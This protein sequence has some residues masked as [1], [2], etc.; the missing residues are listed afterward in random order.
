MSELRLDPTTKEWVIFATE[1]SRRPHE[2]QR[3]GISPTPLPAVNR[4]PFCPGN[5]DLTPATIYQLPFTNPWS[6]RVVPNRFPALRIED[7]TER[8]TNGDLFVTMGGVGAHEVI[9]ES[10]HHDR[11]LPYLSDDEMVAVVRVFLART[12][13]LMRDP[14]FKL[15]LIFKNHG[16]T[17]GTSLEHPHCQLVATPVVPRLVRLKYDVAE[18]HFDITGKCLYCQI[19][20]DEL[21]TGIRVISRTQHFVVLHP[22]ASHV[23]F[24]TWVLPTFHQPSFSSLDDSLVPEFAVLLKQTLLTLTNALGEFA[25]NMI[26][27][28]SPVGEES[29][30]YFLWHVQILPRLVTEAGFELGTGMS[31]NTTL[32]EET[33]EF[34]RNS[35]S[36]SATLPQP[37]FA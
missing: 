8:H 27:Q 4:C 26:I 10:C 31:I 11:P 15:I 5:E 24:E 18:Q 28:T 32:P 34:L 17:A 12:R 22:F 3:P 33:A 36:A 7:E 21:A 25:Y 35:M 30:E 1:R 13:D 29:H 37:V 20:K 14:R 2:F 6:V 16:P 19:V 9:I 23:P